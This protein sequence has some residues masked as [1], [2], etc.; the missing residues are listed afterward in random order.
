MGSDLGHVSMYYTEE[1]PPADQMGKKKHFF[2]KPSLKGLTVGS[3]N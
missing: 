3:P 1:E 2:G